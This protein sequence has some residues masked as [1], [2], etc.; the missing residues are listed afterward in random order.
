M[1]III[2]IQRK[3]SECG[4]KVVWWQILNTLCPFK[5][6]LSHIVTHIMRYSH[7]IYCLVPYTY[8]VVLERLLS[9]VPN[10][11]RWA[12]VKI[13]ILSMSLY[14]HML[15][16][17]L[18]VFLSYK[19]YISRYIRMITKTRYIRLLV[20]ALRSQPLTSAGLFTSWEELFWRSVRFLHGKLEMLV[21]RYI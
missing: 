9:N 4:S 17:I 6:R 21:W 1:L 10:E 12:R 7:C 14:V 20:C 3:A 18:V 16:L 11:S 5:Y 13:V 2:K 15:G 19:Y 8:H